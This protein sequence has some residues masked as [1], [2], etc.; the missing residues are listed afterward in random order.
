M[1]RSV[2]IATEIPPPLSMLKRLGISGAR[3][4]KLTSILQQ[5]RS[6]MDSEKKVRQMVDE[7]M[8]IRSDE[9][10]RDTNPAVLRR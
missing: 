5:V 7:G 10:G 2:S 1:A 3:Q 4:K 8:E 6:Q 9:A